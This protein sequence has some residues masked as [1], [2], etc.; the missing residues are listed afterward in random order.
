MEARNR[1]KQKLIDKFK[2]QIKTRRGTPFLH[3]GGGIF[4]S[5]TR[6][7]VLGI[8]KQPEPGI[9]TNQ[10]WYRRRND[11]ET[12]LL[13][14]QLF[15]EVAG[16]KNVN[17]VVNQETL[18][19]IVEALLWHPVVDH[20]EPDL[21]RAEIAQLFIEAGFNYLGSMKSIPRSIRSTIDDAVDLSGYLV[22]SFKPE[23]ERRYTP[24]TE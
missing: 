18:K 9:N 17:P 16:K 11:V 2:K 19:P 21:K 22:K 20:D 12:A 5:N 10:F 13:D 8:R 15:I 24:P 4:T 23:S 6:K 1:K 7:K 3:M 14:L